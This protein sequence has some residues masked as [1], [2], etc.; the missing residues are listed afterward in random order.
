M[1]SLDLNGN[2]QN[3]KTAQE[4]KMNKLSN[5]LSETENQIKKNQEE[6]ALLMQKTGVNFGDNKPSNVNSA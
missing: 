4:F 3:L 2:Q 1:Q 5:R 6:V